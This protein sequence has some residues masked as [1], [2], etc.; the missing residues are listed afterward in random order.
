MHNSQAHP[1]ALLKRFNDKIKGSF[2]NFERTLLDK[3]ARIANQ[4]VYP[5]YK[6][7]QINN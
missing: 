1:K 7:K 6:N 5:F 3:P 2:E 4:A